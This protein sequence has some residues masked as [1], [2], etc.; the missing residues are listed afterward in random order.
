MVE[1]L[2]NGSLADCSGLVGCWW[3]GRRR[4][5]RRAGRPKAL[6]KK[7]AQVMPTL[8]QMYLRYLSEM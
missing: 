7:V 8:T 2:L 6:Q 5:Q 4:P 1:R 3:L